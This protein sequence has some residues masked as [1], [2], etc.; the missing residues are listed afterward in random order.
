MYSEPLIV[1]N[2]NGF[3][4]AITDSINFRAEINNLKEIFDRSKK[5]IN[6][7]VEIATKENLIKI[8]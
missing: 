4:K 1:V 2:E 5:K 3:K 6:F 7:K 8:L